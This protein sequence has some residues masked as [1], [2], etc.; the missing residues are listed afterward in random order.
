MPQ[1][2]GCP[3]QAPPAGIDSPPALLEAKTENFFASFVE[4]HF[5]HFVPAQ[6][7][8]RTSTSESVSHA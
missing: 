6:S 5:G 1:D 4:P 2:F 7:L 3:V 8:E